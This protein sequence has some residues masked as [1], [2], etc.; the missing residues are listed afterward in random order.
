MGTP[1]ETVPGTDRGLLVGVE[2]YDTAYYLRP[3][4][5]WPPFDID[6]EVREGPASKVAWFS[7]LISDRAV[8]DVGCGRGEQVRAIADLGALLVV[9]VDWSKDAIDIATRFC[10]D[11]RIALF[12]QADAREYAPPLLFQVVTMFDFIEHLEREDAQ[13]VYR[14]CAEMWLSPGGWLCVICPPP[15]ECRYHLYHQTQGTMRRDIEAAGFDIKYLK[16]R[17]SDRGYIYVCRAQLPKQEEE[18][19]VESELADKRHSAADQEG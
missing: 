9:G 16:E 12:C 8:L 15:N 10:R 18:D 13:A 1:R 6:G 14:R 17:K 2:N 11:V 4:D 3:A 5:P 7:D 19:A